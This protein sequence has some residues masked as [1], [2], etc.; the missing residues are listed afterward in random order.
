MRG[1]GSAVGHRV[2]VR[3]AVAV[4]AALFA[5]GC[6]GGSGGDKA[7]G[8]DGFSIEALAS[9]MAAARTAHVRVTGY[10]G[11]PPK[12]GVTT[13]TGKGTESFGTTTGVFDFTHHSAAIHEQTLEGPYDT[14]FAGGVS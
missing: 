4:A 2:R 5:A 14:I 11:L 10:D 3:V 6:S 9:S 8:D 1:Y 13:T 12:P 7:S